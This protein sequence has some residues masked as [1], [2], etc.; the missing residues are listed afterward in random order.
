MKKTFSLLVLSFIIF[1]SFIGCAPKP[2]KPLNYKTPE[3]L[4]YHPTDANGVPE[5]Y[6]VVYSLTGINSVHYVKISELEE[7]NQKMAKYEEYQRNKV[8]KEEYNR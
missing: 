8:L 6:Q 5:G 1:V 3:E 4:K 7:Y 2:P